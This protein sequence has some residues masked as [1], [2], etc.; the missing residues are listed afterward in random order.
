MI[1]RSS[2][3]LLSFISVALLAGCATYT[4]TPFTP[5]PVDTAAYVPKVNAF[6]VVLDTSGSMNFYFKDRPNCFTAKDVVNKMNRTIPALGYKSAL[7]GF[8]S[9]DLFGGEDVIVAYGPATYRS[10]DFGQGLST[11]QCAEGFSPMSQAID[12][13]GETV[14]GVP[15]QV[16]LIV[17]SDFWKIDTSAVGAAIDKL[18]AEYG[19]RLCIHTI[20]VGSARQTDDLTAALAGVN[21]CGSS[22]DAASLDSPD[23]VAGYVTDVLLKP[24]SVPAAVKYRKSTVSASALFDTDKAVLKEGGKTALHALDQSIK[25]KGA[26][27]VVVRVMGHTDSDGPEPYNM[28]LSIR[29]AEAVRQ[30]MVADGV[31]PSLIEVSGEGETKPVASNATAEGRAQNRRVDIIVGS[32]P[33]S[34]K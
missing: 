32:N 24:A 29:R 33:V 17:V 22:V 12:V 21:G 5:A 18:K 14:K 15:G 27:V 25:A 9:G 30:Y 4:P 8:G 6:V 2:S 7:V 3:T 28:A 26:N 16:A 10:A 13:G 19:D 23:A 1:I 11:L 31:A 34:E 20:K